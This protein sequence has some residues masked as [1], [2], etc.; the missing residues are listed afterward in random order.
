MGKGKE[1]ESP[2]G[3]GGGK[4]RRSQSDLNLIARSAMG[5]Q[6]GPGGYPYYNSFSS[7]NLQHYPPGTQESYNSFLLRNLM[8]GKGKE[9]ESPEGWG[10]G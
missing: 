2:E 6:R 7:R 9:L 10:G 3:W 8:I 5:Q 4:G 1:L